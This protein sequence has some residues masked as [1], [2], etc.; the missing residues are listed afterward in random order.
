MK[1]YK[2]TVSHTVALEGSQIEKSDSVRFNL[3]WRLCLAI[4]RPSSAS[5]S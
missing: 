1:K 5:S 4:A 3:C 2:I